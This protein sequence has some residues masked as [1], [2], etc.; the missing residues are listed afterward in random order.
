MGAPAQ[1]AAQA[2]DA[3]SL[4]QQLTALRQGSNPAHRLF[5]PGNLCLLLPLPVP[6]HH[7]ERT[8]TREHHEVSL[9]FGDGTQQ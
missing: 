6:H 9:G 7:T 8:Q 3:W 5:S 1:K 4:P 2:L